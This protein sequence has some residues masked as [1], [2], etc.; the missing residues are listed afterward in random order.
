MNVPNDPLANSIAHEFAFD[1]DDLIANR[2]GI[3]SRNQTIKAGRQGF[4]WLF[5]A[6]MLG[7][8]FLF[9]LYMT[10]LV[11]KVGFPDIFNIIFALFFMVLAAVLGWRSLKA[12]LSGAVKSIIGRVDFIQ[13][14][15]KLF[16]RVGDSEIQFEVVP[17]MKNLFSS[18]KEYKVYYC[19]IDKTILSLEEM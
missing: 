7:L 2:K 9:K 15:K 8:A 18:N 12:S 14:K 13:D 3:M 5:L 16:L 10:W 1:E 19:E 6:V 11:E 17:E 4:I